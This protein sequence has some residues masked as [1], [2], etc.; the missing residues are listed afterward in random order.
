MRETVPLP[1]Q[2]F[3]PNVLC[4]RASSVDYD[5]STI[6]GLNGPSARELIGPQI[7]KSYIYCVDGT[8]QR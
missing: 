7:V 1:G 3:R 2:N 5:G 8:T 6:D 4:L